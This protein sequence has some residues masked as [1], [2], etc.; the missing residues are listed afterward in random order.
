ENVF[1]ANGSGVAVMFTN[2][3]EMV[4]N[5]F[6]DAK[7]AASYGLLL[8]EMTDSRLTGN[9]FAGNSVGLVAEG[10]TRLEARGNEFRDNGKAIA[11]TA[12][13]QEA[14]FIGNG[15]ADNSFDVT[16]NSGNTRAEFTGNYWDD[17]RGY[18]L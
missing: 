9:L 7:G 12:S 17:Y 15:F 11:L 1:R 10:A 3:A 4:E 2:R 6:L 13:S 16:T 5:Q 14:R 18:D 8:K